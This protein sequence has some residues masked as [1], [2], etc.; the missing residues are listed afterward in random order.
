MNRNELKHIFIISLLLTLSFPPFPFGF[1]A[2]FALCYFMW[3][4]QDKTTKDSFRLGY[5]LGLIWGA[6]TLF[7][8]SA[9]TLP[10]AIV[11]IAINAFHY[12]I[13]WWIYA[14]FRKSSKTFALFSLPF[15][16]V[17]LEYLRLFSDIRFNWLTL[18]YTKPIIVL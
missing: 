11:A 17:G 4:I 13:V 8:I 10:G 6:F 7:W 18:A 5:W 15:I 14:H 3:F 9:S 16:W 2:P 1:L 12:A